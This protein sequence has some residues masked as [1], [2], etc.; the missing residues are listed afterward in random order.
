[1]PFFP[2]PFQT[3]VLEEAIIDVSNAISRVPETSYLSDQDLE[4]QLEQGNEEAHKAYDQLMDS[5]FAVP[6]RE[7]IEIIDSAL[8]SYTCT[9]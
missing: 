7:L 9:N 5:R 6:V 4:I 3:A 8:K 2:L 1:M